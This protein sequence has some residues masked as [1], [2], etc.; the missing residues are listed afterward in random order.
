MSTVIK[1]VLKVYLKKKLKRQQN[2]IAKTVLK[3]YKKHA[4]RKMFFKSMY[5]AMVLF[6]FHVIDSALISRC[7]GIHYNFNDKGE[8]ICLEK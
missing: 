8:I 6:S 5:L 1:N 7:P 3:G 2:S 4:H